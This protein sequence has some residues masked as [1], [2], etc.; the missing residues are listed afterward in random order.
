MINLLPPSQIKQ[1]QEEKI[2]KI[3]LHFTL[4]IL[5]FFI[6]FFLILLSIK[7]YLQG[8]LESKRIFFEQSESS[9]DLDLE[10]AIKEYNDLLI[11]INNFQE[12]KTYLFPIFE[13]ISK[14]IPE[15]IS[16]DT[17]SIELKPKKEI[18]VSLSGF[19]QNREGFM[20]FVKI[21][22]EKYT[23]VS[24]SPESLLKQTSLDFSISF[25]I[26]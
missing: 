11:K 20:E 2:L 18:V 26:K 24:F 17:F 7:I 5:F 22:S 16:L 9:L 13:E 6:S 1:L 25:Q 14:N 8:I 19:S 10:K 15:K 4:F 21:L 12:Q 23:K 3:F